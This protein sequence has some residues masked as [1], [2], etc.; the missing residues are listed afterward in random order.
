MI[1]GLRELGIPE[2]EIAQVHLLMMHALEKENAELRALYARAREDAAAAWQAV[3]EERRQK[4]TLA[5]KIK[6][7]A[8]RRT[9]NGERH[10]VMPGE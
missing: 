1:V 10:L 6:Q 2:A 4:E 7:S 3:A 5:Q 9:L 8:V